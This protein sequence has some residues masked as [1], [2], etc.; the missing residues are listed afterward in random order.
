MCLHSISMQIRHAPV[1][2]QL[3]K[4]MYIIRVNPF[5][6]VSSSMFPVDWKFKLLS[7]PRRPVTAE[8]RLQTSRVTKKKKK[9][10]YCVSDSTRLEL[11]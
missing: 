4:T 8:N 3:I 9:K 6:E 11:I 7:L 10:V 2:K 1:V 5:L